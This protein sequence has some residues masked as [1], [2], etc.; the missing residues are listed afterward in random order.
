[1]YD[2]YKEFLASEVDDTLKEKE[3]EDDDDDE[4]HVGHSIVAVDQSAI[5]GE[6]LAVSYKKN[7]LTLSNIFG[8]NSPL[9]THLLITGR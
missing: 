5:T 3:D 6:S 4:H 2:R 7:S 9:T 1:M 8:M